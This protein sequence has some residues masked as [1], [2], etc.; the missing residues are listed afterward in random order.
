MLETGRN[1]F[2]KFINMDINSLVVLLELTLHDLRTVNEDIDEKD[3]LD[4]V[5]ILCDLGQTVMI[6]DY[7]EYYKLVMYISK[8]TSKRIGLIIGIYNMMNILNKKY[9]KNL[10]GGLISSFGL[11]FGKNVKLYIY[12][13]LLKNDKLLTCKNIQI[14]PSIYGLFRYLQDNNRMKDIKGANIDRLHIISDNVLNM[15]KKGERGWENF[16]PDKVTEAIKKNSLF[17]YQK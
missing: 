12:P 2:L 16:V 17:N 9:Y 8:L 13:Y 10:E 4:R 7:P 14:E 3:F 5:D 6:S 1:Q 11:L 15:I